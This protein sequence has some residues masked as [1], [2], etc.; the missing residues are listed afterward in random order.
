MKFPSWPKGTAIKSIQVHMFWFLCEPLMGVSLHSDIVTTRVYQWLWQSSG[1]LRDLQPWVPICSSSHVVMCVYYE[2]IYLKDGVAHT[3][4]PYLYNTN[5]HKGIYQGSY[6]LP[7]ELQVFMVNVV[8]EVRILPKFIWL[9][10][11]G[12][13][14][15][16]FVLD[17]RWILIQLCG[18]HTLYITLPFWCLAISSTWIP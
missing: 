16:R 17:W 10:N 8:W 14:Q 11:L 6:I 15:D 1:Q 2:A 18:V 7:S 9:W 5:I 12:L 4:S 3:W 13:I